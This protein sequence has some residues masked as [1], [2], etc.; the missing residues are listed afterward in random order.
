MEHCQDADLFL[1]YPIKDR[2]RKLAHENATYIGTVN[3]R[4]REWRTTNPIEA[5]ANFDAKLLPETSPDTFVITVGFIELGP[6]IR[7]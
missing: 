1:H 4:T 5:L 3:D 6:G 2:V 7:F